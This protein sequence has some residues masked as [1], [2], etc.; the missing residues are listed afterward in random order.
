[1][2][3]IAEALKRAEEERNRNLAEQMAGAVTAEP[4]PGP[5]EIAFEDRFG[6][7]SADSIVEPPA[8]PRP[9]IVTAVPIQPGSI[10]V[11]VVALHEPA[12]ITAE[13]YR[14]VR[15]RLLTSNPSGEPRLHAVTSSLPRE[16]KTTTAANLAFSLAELR[17]LRVAL[18]DLDWRQR[19]LELLLGVKGRPGV[20]E[21][22][23][24]EH[25][26]AEVCVPLVRSNLHFVPAGELKDATPT[27]LLS[28]ERG[29][30]LF[31]ELKERFHYALIDTPPVHTVADIGLIAPLCHSTLFVIR[32]NVAPEPLV[33]RCV[34]MLQ[35]NGTRIAGAVLAGECDE[36]TGG[37]ET[38]DFYQAAGE[39]S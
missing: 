13:R 11:S 36:T 20:A 1:M 32:M 24:G 15:T 27:E 31:R 28:C 30:A 34:R 26:L 23:R 18:L 14:S 19:G 9:F 3:R 22:I 29:A 6:E 12:S 10:H 2:G 7:N 33:R 25:S 35:A 21:V 38:L 8:G 39:E 5:G 37:R 4:A 17:H 16:G